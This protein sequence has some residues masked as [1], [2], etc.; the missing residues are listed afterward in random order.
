MCNL[1]LSKVKWVFFGFNSVIDW[2]GLVMRNFCLYFEFLVKNMDFF[3]DR[4]NY[5][6][7]IMVF[8]VSVI[9]MLILVGIC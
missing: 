5:Y 2:V 4:F 3:I 1:F 9:I 7:L 6:Y 8:V